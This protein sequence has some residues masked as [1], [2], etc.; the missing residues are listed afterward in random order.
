MDRMNSS[1]RTANLGFKQCVGK[2]CTKQGVIEL[3]IRF[4]NK[5][6]WFCESCKKELETHELVMPSK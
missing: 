3:R 5:T 4:I 2:S 6:G 1:N